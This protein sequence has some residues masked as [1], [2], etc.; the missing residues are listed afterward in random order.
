MASFSSSAL[1]SFCRAFNWSSKLGSVLVVED[2]G[3]CAGA[4]VLPA[5]AVDDFAAG[6]FL[7]VAGCAAAVFDAFLASS[8]GLVAAAA[9]LGAVL[10]VVVAGF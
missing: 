5:A 7:S 6:A 10:V 2:V 1:S 4:E 9:V 8:T 3:F